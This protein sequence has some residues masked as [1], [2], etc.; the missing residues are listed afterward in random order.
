MI[1]RNAPP[2]S[3]AMQTVGPFFPASLAEPA[4]ATLTRDGHAGEAIWLTGDIADE[5][6]PFRNAILEL[7]QADAKGRVAGD[8]GADKH[9]AFW[10]RAASDGAGQF[11][12]RTVL[13]GPSADP[14]GPR[15]PCFELLILGSGIMRRLA[16]CFFPPGTMQDPVLRCVPAALRPRLLLR[17]AGKRGGLRRLHATIRLHGADETPFFR[18]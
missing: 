15:A 7:S 3:T 10:G 14:A 18:D 6:G 9:F 17:D 13:P 5:S 11:A 4:L 1:R 2:P 8:R 12:F 16:T